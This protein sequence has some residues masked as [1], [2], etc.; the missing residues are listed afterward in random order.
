[1]NAKQEA[2]LNMQRGIE[3]H[4]DAN[5]IIITVV[6]AFVAAFNKIKAFNAQI[7]ALVGGQE[8]SR[9]GVAADKR[10]AESAL[11]DATLK[12]AKIVRAFAADTG[13]NTL[14]DEV[15]LQPTD[16]KRLRDDQLAPRCQI[17]HDRATANLA[18]LKDYGLTEVKLTDFQ[19][20][21]DAYSSQVL[22]PR[23]SRAER[24]VQP[25][26]IENIFRESRKAF[27]ITDDLIDNFADDH[28][29]L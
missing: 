16:L 3:Q 1:M 21:I 8:A 14:R 10:A 13:N 5:T 15:D 19:N 23:A 18:A 17:I 29:I 7:I 20:K 26:Q 12:I 25:A 24:A 2:E 22:K 11:M 6:A 28:P 4:L 27:A 9:T